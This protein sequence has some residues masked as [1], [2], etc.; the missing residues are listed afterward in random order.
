M[1]H[2]D[3][4]QQVVE[5]HIISLLLQTLPSIHLSLPAGIRTSCWPWAGPIQPHQATQDAQ[6]QQQLSSLWAFAH[7]IFSPG[8]PF[9]P[10]LPGTSCPFF[11]DS[12]VMPRPSRSH[13]ELEPR[14]SHAHPP[15]C[16]VCTGHP[17]LEPLSLGS[18]Q[19]YT[20]DKASPLDS[21]LLQGKDF[22]CISGLD[23]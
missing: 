6:R 7:A 22:L 19:W 13:P 2:R 17:L 4:P 8:L 10:W 1:G 18:T 3:G 9:F 15:A 11:S 23:I 20:S 14:V 5:T 16:A 12:S 21:E